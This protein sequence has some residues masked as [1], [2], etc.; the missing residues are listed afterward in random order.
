MIIVLSFTS[1]E[2]GSIGDSGQFTTM[3]FWPSV[4][5]LL[6]Q[7]VVQRLLRAVDDRGSVWLHLAGKK[8]RLLL[9]FGCALEQVVLRLCDLSCESERL[10]AILTAHS[11]DLQ[12]VGLR[13]V[14]IGRLVVPR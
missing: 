1:H 13:D 5:H 2:A 8:D 4:I 10:G 11:L 6:T 14:E 3:S 9:V 7:D 12:H